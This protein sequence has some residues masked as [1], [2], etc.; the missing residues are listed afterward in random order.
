MS[1][2]VMWTRT[3]IFENNSLVSRGLVLVG[4]FVF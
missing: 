2:V 3:V 4:F 1:E